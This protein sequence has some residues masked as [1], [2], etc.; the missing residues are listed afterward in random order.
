MQGWERIARALLA[1]LI[2]PEKIGIT[3][4]CLAAAMEEIDR[5][6]KKAI[7]R[8]TMTDRPIVRVEMI[9]TYVPEVEP[10]QKMS[11]GASGFDV[12]AAITQPLILGGL[13]RAKVPTGL[14]MQI[15]RGYEGQVRP[16]SGWSYSRG[17][18]VLNSPG[19][20]DSDYRGEVSV[21]L[22]NLGGSPITIRPGDRI[23]QVVFAPVAN[24]ELM[25][26]TRLDETERGDGGFGSTGDGS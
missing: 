17:L 16:R 8:N 14:A 1:A 15:A 9:R 21:L 11:A 3:A 6:R 23:A 4:N 12:C 20:I 22:V 18:T 7:Q 26:V 25:I 5:L 24:P 2:K 19:T 10:P 13:Q